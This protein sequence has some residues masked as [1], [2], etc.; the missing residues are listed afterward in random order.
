[1]S[2]AVPVPMSV[3]VVMRSGVRVVHRSIP[4]R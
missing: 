2:V 4:I 3:A 1:M